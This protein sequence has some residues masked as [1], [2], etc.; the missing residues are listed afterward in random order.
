MSEKVDSSGND[1]F[2]FY[3]YLFD[4]YV[5]LAL[6]EKHVQSKFY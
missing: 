6:V 5:F 2:R 4:N 3:T 1:Y